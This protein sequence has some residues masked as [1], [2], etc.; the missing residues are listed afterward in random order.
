MGWLSGKHLK[1]VIVR[2][3]SSY[4]QGLQQFCLRQFGK[5]SMRQSAEI[6]KREILIA[7]M[8]KIIVYW[9]ALV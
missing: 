7:N 2:R 1:T 3:E 5:S 8:S 4:G 9:L 6:S